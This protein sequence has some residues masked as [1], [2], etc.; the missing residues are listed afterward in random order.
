MQVGESALCASGGHP[1]PS[2]GKP[3]EP[4]CS[5]RERRSPAAATPWVRRP[6][7]LSARAEVTRRSPPRTSTAAAALCASGGHPPD[8]QRSLNSAIC[9][10]RERRS[11]AVGEKGPSRHALLSA[12][13]EVTRRSRTPRRPR[14]PALCASGGHPANSEAVYSSRDC[15]LRERRSPGPGRRGPG[16][17]RLLSARAEVTRPRPR[18]RGCAGTALCA[19]GGHPF[20]LIYLVVNAA[21]SLR[22]RRSPAVAPVDAPASPLL[23]AR[24]EVTRGRDQCPPTSIPALCASG[25]HPRPATTVARGSSCSLR[26]RRSPVDEQDGADLA[27]LLSARAEV[28]RRCPGRR[29]P[30]RP[31]LCASGGHPQPVLLGALVGLCSLRE[32]RSPAVGGAGDRGAPLL[33]A[34]AQ[35]TRGVMG[36]MAELNAALCASGGHPAQEAADT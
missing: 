16:R 4:A 35:V 5:L 9:S 14:R 3:P 26:E 34:R 27:G 22:E 1:D 31:A 2:N 6:A 13:A 11:P 21:C 12:R 10:L 36:P 28:T 8:L 29:S 15:S 33:S 20:V 23:S 30:P 25:G 7:L 32:R 19:S 24:A 17:R 18:R